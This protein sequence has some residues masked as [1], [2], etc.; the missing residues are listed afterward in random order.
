MQHLAELA[1]LFGGLSGLLGS[2]FLAIPLFHLLS[3][4]EALE[5]LEPKHYGPDSRIFDSAATQIRAYIR[6]R[7]YQ[8]RTAAIIGVVLL[9]LGLVLTTVQIVYSLADA[10][11]A[12]TPQKAQ[13]LLSGK[14]KNDD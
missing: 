4:R 9:F 7:R 2:L 6:A 5:D 8:W 13:P 12:A 10:G 1:G 3:A 11:E 14:A